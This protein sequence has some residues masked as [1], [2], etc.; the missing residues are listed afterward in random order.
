[1]FDTSSTKALLGPADPARG[2]PIPPPHARAVDLIA[3]AEATV[4]IDAPS[5]VRRR[6][7][8][9]PVAAGVAAAGLVATG[10]V[11]GGRTG[12][13]LSGVTAGQS[14]APTP[15]RTAAPTPTWTAAPAPTFG[16]VIRPVAFEFDK[17]PPAT[18]DQLRALAA[19]LAPSRCDTTTGKYTFIHTIGWNAVFD[20]TP[21]GKSQ[22]IIPSEKWWWRAADGS[23]RDRTTLLPAVYPNEESYRY[24]QKHPV[25]PT[26]TPAANVLDLP[27]NPDRAIL[28]LPTDPAEIAKKLLTGGKPF[29]FWNVRDWFSSHA[30]PL[31]TRAE[32]LR[33]LANT[34]GVVW[35]GETTDR[36]GRKGVA[37]SLDDKG[38]RH[39]LIFDPRT[40]EMLAWDDV[41]RPVDTVAGSTLLLAC[42][43]TDKLG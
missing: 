37:V 21:D 30:V 24:Y 1:M 31:A 4:T 41:E 29:L 32:V 13:H 27:P 33:I 25:Q 8:L 36:A 42:E 26:G 34:P 2:V 43:R 6:R 23:E 35:R 17:Q 9:V 18:G 10:V 15:T 40:G 20:D 38:A 14:T 3:L 16:P 12:G 5:G 28:A 19:H 7:I 39:V 22:R 11:A